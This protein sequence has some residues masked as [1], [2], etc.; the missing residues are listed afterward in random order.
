MIVPCRLDDLPCHLDG[1]RVK[2]PW[3][4]PLGTLQ[5]MVKQIKLA[6]QYSWSLS[7]KCFYN[8]KFLDWKKKV[9][10]TMNCFF[11]IAMV[12]FKNHILEL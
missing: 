1:K 10:I 11:L 7:S 3:L 9:G 2:N 4:V 5:G 6:K 8:Y 12:F